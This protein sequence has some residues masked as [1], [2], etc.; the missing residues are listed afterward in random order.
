[1]A[2]PAAR[3]PPPAAKPQKLVS[4]PSWLSG[5]L[6]ANTH[7]GGG[8]WR[9]IICAGAEGVGSAA[10][11]SARVAVAVVLTAAAAGE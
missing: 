1:M 9:E 5:E 8:K 7:A 6:P 11:E 2:A 3:P 4:G 10:A